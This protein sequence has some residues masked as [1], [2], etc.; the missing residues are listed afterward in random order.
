MKAITFTLLI[1]STL[2][3]I[4][5][6]QNNLD[7]RYDKRS[8]DY[9]QNPINLQVQNPL[10]QLQQFQQQQ[11]TKP[12]LVSITSPYVQNSM[13]NQIQ[14][15][16]NF[17][18]GRKDLF[19]VPVGLPFHPAE[20]FYYAGQGF[21]SI[22]NN[23]CGIRV[24]Y[25]VEILLNNNYMNNPER[26]FIIVY[27]IKMTN[28]QFIAIEVTLVNNMIINVNRCFYESD[29]NMIKNSLQIDYFNPQIF[30]YYTDLKDQ[31]KKNQKFQNIISAYG[32]D[33]QNEIHWSQLRINNINEM[34]HPVKALEIAFNNINN[35]SQN[36]SR[37]LVLNVSSQQN[38]YVY[39]FR[40]DTHDQNKY[41]LGMK[42]QMNNKLEL[43]TLIF[44]RERKNCENLLRVQILTKEFS[45]YY[46][47]ITTQFHNECNKNINHFNQGYEKNQRAVN[48]NFDSSFLLGS[49]G[50]GDEDVKEKKK[51]KEEVFTEEEFAEEKK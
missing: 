45:D 4:P 13:N 47:D 31:I 38:F 20:L 33:N 34:F 11:L 39:L 51:E 25:F 32:W 16:P 36:I 50:P 35:I 5:F 41:Y 12:K 1:I 30:N 7:D 8:Y 10:A 23:Q 24:I 43:I 27:S 9:N 21:Q 44:D 48:S 17:R 6:Q 2:T 29:L 19:D 18:N 42:F 26:K 28:E 3:M 15:N 49:S 14:Y 22:L 46:K 40:I 37:I